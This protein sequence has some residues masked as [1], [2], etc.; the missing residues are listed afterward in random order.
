MF[1]IIFMNVYLI[2]RKLEK[3]EN[4]SQDIYSILM[5]IYIIE[6]KNDKKDIFI[7]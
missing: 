7:L 2:W 4:R 5:G 6:M 3:W 1:K